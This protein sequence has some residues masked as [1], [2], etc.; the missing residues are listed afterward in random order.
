[1][2]TMNINYPKIL[3]LLSIGLFGC[4][5]HNSDDY[6]TPGV[7]ESPNIVFILADDLGYGDLQS[8]N[9]GAQISTPN[10]SKLA[11]QGTIFINAH[12]GSSICT[13]SRYGIL[14]GRYAFRSSLKSGVLDGW[15]PALIET[16]RYTIA[17]LAGEAGYQ[18][19]IVGKWHLGMNWKPIN[20]AYPAVQ[21]NGENISNV[22]FTQPVL[23]GPNKLGFDYSYILPASLDMS[24]YTYLENGISTDVPL[25]PFQG[26]DFGRGITWRE[27]VASGSFKI[28]NT[29]DHFTDKAVN[30][31]IQTH[32]QSSKPFFLYFTLTAPHTPWLP[33][34]QF[35]GK[36]P[37]A[38]VYGDFV[39]HTDYAVGRIL[40]CL[41]S[42]NLAQNTLVIF[43]SDNGADWSA[44]DK[45]QFPGHKANYIFRGRKSDIWDA[46]HH[47]PVIMRWPGTIAAKRTFSQSFSLNDMMATFAGMFG[48]QLPS[49][50]GPDS[51]NQWPLIKNGKGDERPS[52][53]YHSNEGMFAIQQG[54]WKF[55]DG[56]GSGG[57]SP[58]GQ[59]NAP[60]QLYDMEK[61]PGETTN[62]YTKYP[63]VVQELKQLLNQQKS[64][65]FSVG[66]P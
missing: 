2:R 10:L 65:G 11:S 46:G 61:D 16:N 22:D 53:I 19:A 23:N 6:V 28:E 14:T 5:K 9:S 31:L 49:G 35:K 62:L 15:S 54:K 38:G 8:F 57:W 58:N 45:A 56:V 24:P 43:A 26:G 34:E 52:I 55:I 47:I 60:G 20:P 33:A 29:L 44:D 25:V 30:Y 7:K 1:M 3:L 27:G 4:K 32:K 13:P 48:R 18:T 21:N 63:E 40:K 66:N 37:N 36:N 64:Q 39:N 42:L 50:A 12:S 51:Y 41:D 59:D 17:K